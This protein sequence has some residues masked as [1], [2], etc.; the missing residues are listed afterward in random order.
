MIKISDVK[1]SPFDTDYKKAVAKALR[2]KETDVL[3]IEILRKSLDCRKRDF[4]HYV[5]TFKAEVK[6]EENFLKLKNVSKYVED[7][8]VFP[9]EK[10]NGKIVIAGSGP[11][12]LFC[13]LMLA[14]C[15]MN[16]IIL[17]RGEAVEKRKQSVDNFFKTGKLNVN[18][19]IQFGEGGAGTFSDG[20]LTCGLN[21]KKIP[22]INEEFVKH[23]APEEIKYSAKPHIGTDYLYKTVKAIRE[24]IISLGG[25][26]LFETTLKDLVVE[27]NKLTAVVT[28]KET[29][30]CNKLVLATGHSCR[31][32]YRMLYEKGVN[33]EKKPFSVGVR[34]EH[35]RKY[36]NLLQYKT[37]EF[38]QTLPAADYKLSCHKENRGAYT[39][40]MCP[41]G[42]VVCGA[43]GEGQVVTNGMSYFARNQE[44]SNAALLV[45]VLPEDINGT[46]LDAINFQEDLEKKAYIKGGENYF[47]P[48][49]LVCDFLEDRESTKAGEVKPSYL[50]GVKYT[51]IKDI[52]PDF[53]TDM[54]KFA[55][56]EFNK[57]MKGFNFNDA[58]LTGVE[59]RSSAP[60]RILRD[61]SFQ[62]NIKGLYPIG[63]GAGY[64]GGIMSSAIDGINCAEKI[65]EN[66]KWRME[67]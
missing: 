45:S 26:F 67:N 48:V 20:K 11:A 54:L 8:Y 46:V 35:K 17:E 44:N 18:S 36:I 24:E 3:N 16:P 13:G 31:D 53:V 59:T 47:A 34:I 65:I 32:T 38:A 25:K 57:K 52:L 56:V 9:Y 41:G 64:A 49:Q 6:N 1:L 42:V 12:G 2:T 50:P 23:G 63:E 62:A 29:I 15:G 27:N 66:G 43:S 39:F 37:E 55:I 58:V 14:R 19:N 22:F 40:C 61:E 60:L 51:S 30:K 4:I 5:L 33:M 28:D 21:N 7:K 10:T